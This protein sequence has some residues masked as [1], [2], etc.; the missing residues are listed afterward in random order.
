MTIRPMAIF[1][2]MVLVSPFLPPFAVPGITVA[3]F[4]LMFDRNFGSHFFDPAAGG[5]P[6]LWQHL[7]WLFGHPEVFI[8]ILP[9][10]GVVSEILPVFCRRPLF[11]YPV[12]VLSSIPIGFMGCGVW[13][14]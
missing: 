11:G 8:L 3:L 2:W 5:D 13:A 10:F 14:H 7:F 9:A 12:M 1:S 4:L 6:V